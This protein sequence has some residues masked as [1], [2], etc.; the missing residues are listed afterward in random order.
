MEKFINPYKYRTNPKSAWYCW[1]SPTV[2][3]CIFVVGWAEPTSTVRFSAIWWAQPTLQQEIFE[4]LGLIV[5]D[6]A[7]AI[8]TDLEN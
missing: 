4:S 3:S 8:K 7:G 5:S 6:R 1:I 2:D